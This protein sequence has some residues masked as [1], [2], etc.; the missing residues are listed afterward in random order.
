MDEQT[1]KEMAQMLKVLWINIPSTVLEQ[2]GLDE[3]ELVTLLAKIE[4]K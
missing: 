2:Y 4:G 3:N 1:V